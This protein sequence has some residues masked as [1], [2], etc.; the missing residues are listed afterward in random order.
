MDDQINSRRGATWA[1]ATKRLRARVPLRLWDIGGGE[2]T[3]SVL[4]QR[5][6]FFTVHARKRHSK[7][8]GRDEAPN[9]T[10]VP[11]HLRSTITC[12][13]PN[14]SSLAAQRPPDLSCHITL[15]QQCQCP[16]VTCEGPLGERTSAN[17]SHTFVLATRRKS[18]ASLQ[19]VFQLA[20][21]TIFTRLIA[22]ILLPHC[23]ICSG[24]T[25]HSVKGERRSKSPVAREC[26]LK[27]CVWRLRTKVGVTNSKIFSKKKWEGLD[28][29]YA[30]RHARMSGWTH[31]SL[32]IDR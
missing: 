19:Q 13:R 11:V 29:T 7:Q 28:S 20:S 10:T 12:L 26:F 9:L 32:T 22:L 25:Q 6:D 31:R 30:T 5:S 2:L 27:S 24:V 4:E 8:P 18:H 21:L 14:K 15:A 3:G 1:D 16:R 17:C 23:C